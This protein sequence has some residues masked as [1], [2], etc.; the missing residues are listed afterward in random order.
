D[1][2]DVY[3]DSKSTNVDSLRVA[4]ESFERPVVLIAGGQ[5]KGADYR[6]LRAL[7]EARVK[8]LVTLGEDAPKLEEAFGDLVATGRASDMDDALRIGLEAATGGNVLLLLPGCASFDMYE[9]FEER[10]RHF[11]ECVLRQ[12]TL[13]QSGEQLP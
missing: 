10:G 2:V 5:G 1:G 8:Y 13:T 4:L 11:K 12:A 7:V 6:V 3:N 9:N